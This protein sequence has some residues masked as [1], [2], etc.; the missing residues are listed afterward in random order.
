MFRFLAISCGADTL[1]WVLKL[2]V[3]GTPTAYDPSAVQTNVSALG[4]RVY[5]NNLPFRLNTPMDIALSS[6][7]KLEA[8]PVKQ[9][10]ATLAP[11]RFAAVATLLAEY[12]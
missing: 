4:I 3:R 7:P 6:P 8:V 11:A 1:P 2:S 9:P 10:G 5:Q 12:E